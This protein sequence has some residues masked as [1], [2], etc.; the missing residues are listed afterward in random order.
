MSHNGFRGMTR[1][2]KDEVSIIILLPVIFF[3]ENESAKIVSDTVTSRTGYLK[4]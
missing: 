2:L 1:L 3:Y 4:L